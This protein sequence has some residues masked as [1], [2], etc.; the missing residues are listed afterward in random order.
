M[1]DQETLQ[2]ELPKN[3]SIA[4]LNTLTQ[5]LLRSSQGDIVAILGKHGIAADDA[6]VVAV[7]ISGAAPEAE[8]KG[9]GS[10]ADVVAIAISLVPL[11]KALTP[12][13]L[14]FS[15]KGA[16]LAYEI[17]K[18]IWL[19]LKQKLLGQNVRL[20]EKKKKKKR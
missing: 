15:K 8:Y 3:L 19:M 11:I 5:E 10:V 6:K 14:P 18:D 12:L 9:A 17:G 1:N 7:K 16:E 4:R 20:S 13:L 2:Y